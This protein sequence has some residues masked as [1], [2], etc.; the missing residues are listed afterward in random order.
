MKHHALIVELH[1]HY[2][3]TLNKLAGEQEL[4]VQRPGVAPKCK[5][6]HHME[7]NGSSHRFLKC[8]LTQPLLPGNQMS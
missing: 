5:A 2:W 7:D 6:A 8:L 3:K 4:L 1:H